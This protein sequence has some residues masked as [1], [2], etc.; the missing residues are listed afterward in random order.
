MET[1]RGRYMKKK[2]ILIL[3]IIIAII[4]GVIGY[5]VVKDLQQEDIL[6]QEVVNL[7][8]KDLLKDDYTIE[9]KTTGDYAYIEEAIKKF[10]KELS[11][12]IKILNYY[13]TDEELINLLA[14]ESLIA[15][16]P[17]FT[18]SYQILEN[19]RIQITQAIQSI[20]NLCEED[21][22]KNL[23]DKEKVDEY[24]YE[25]YLQL[26]YTEKDLKT[27]T[28]TKAQ[29][30]E[31]SSNLNLFLDKVKEMLNLLE[32][33]NSSW[34]IIDGQIYFSTNQL[35]DQYNSLYNELNTIAT[36]KFQSSGNTNPSTDENNASN[37]KI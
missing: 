6:K 23:I 10:Y 11:D 17:N 30:E 27:F 14:P 9:V 3:G 20:A 34:E 5:L 29:M 36:E 32:K 18:N 4:V 16:R 1:E 21:T 28:E 26:M 19:A 13:I 33:N 35:V 25:F 7:S 24:S 31:L 2:I 37:N 8:N 15:N 12:S 22:I